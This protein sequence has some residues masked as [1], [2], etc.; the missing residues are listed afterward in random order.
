VHIFSRILVL[1]RLQTFN[2]FSIFHHENPGQT[3]Q[4]SG[5]WF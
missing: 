3:G 4:N 5:V 1:K 2:L